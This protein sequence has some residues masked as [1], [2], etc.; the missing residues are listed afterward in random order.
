M[1]S[2]LRGARLF[3]FSPLHKLYY[4]GA[5]VGSSLVWGLLLYASARRGWTG[6][7]AAGI[8]VWGLSLALGGQSY[9]YA[10]YQA[11]LSRDLTLF[12]SDMIGSVVNQLWA[13]ASSYAAS[14]LPFLGVT[15]VLW[16]A[17]RQL[18]RPRGRL[19]R[20]A[21]AGALLA[22]V[23]CWLVPI[24]VRQQQA[25]TPD[26][27]YLNAIGALVA[28]QLGFVEESKQ[29]RPRSRAA[30]PV[31]PIS[32][33]PPLSRNVLLI[34]TESQR[35]DAACSAYD[36]DCGLTPY[37]NRLLPNRHPLLQLRALDS[38]TAVSLAVLLAGV[39][40][41]E[42]REVMHTWPLLF[43]YARAAG[44]STAYW[45][46][47]NLLFANSRLFVENLGVDDF[48]SGTQLQSDADI[49]VGADE[50][51]LAEYV[52]HRLGSLEEPFLAML[53]L[54]NTHYPFLV[55][56]DGEQP[57][58]PAR[59]DKTEEGRQAFRNYYQNALVQQDAELAK[60]LRALRET[61]AGKRTVLVYTSDHG[62][63]F[64]DH[65]QV[66]HT[67][68][69]F[70]EEV[71]VPGFV[72]A[73]PGTLTASERRQ[74]VRHRE[75]FVFHPDLMVTMLD[76]IGVWDAAELDPF[77]PRVIGSSLLRAP[78]PA[79]NM[80]MTNC[81]AV[82]SCAFENWGMMRGH[83]KLAART[84][85]DT[86]WHCYDLLADPKEEHR[87]QLPLCE[88]LRQAALQ[89]FGRPPN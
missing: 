35:A 83:I 22:L 36:P 81:A 63:A 47:Q 45:T 56:E 25:A 66:G 9:F 84:P 37:T 51:L 40:P 7:T 14:V 54:S 34:L 21:G 70:D 82:W 11:Y 41:H 86:G 43:D 88:E 5:L 42:T 60:V 8:F 3:G 53:H 15:F 17:S 79:R 27:L 31:A 23:L 58:Q 38:T 72:D 44:W 30:R 89:V 68:S 24:Q 33:R 12:A 13:D 2:S 69:L 4:L 77:T 16:A 64:R 50:R 74:L 29:I 19:R 61:D 52:T 18:V 20:V 46:S 28:S 87:I 73:P 67:F 62:E 32:A 55:R 49:D 78:R 59:L 57:F 75:R 10:Q 26:A 39:G 48:V 85:F 76:L 71:K 65:G 80:P 6:K 1:D